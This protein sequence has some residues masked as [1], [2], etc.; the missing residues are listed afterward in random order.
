[1]EVY[2]TMR[3]FWVIFFSVFTA[4]VVALSLIFVFATRET[5]KISADVMYVNVGDTFSLTLDKKNASNSTKI[6]AESSDLSV[7]TF[8]MESSMAVAKSGGV[9]RITFT[10]TNSRYRSL[11]C[12]VMVG[13]GT[14]ENPFYIATAEDLAQIGAADSIYPA[15][16]CYRLVANIDMSQHND[17]IWAPIAEFSGV[18][19]GNGYTITN[20]VIGVNDSDNNETL[21]NAGIFGT[22]SA[23]GK[24]TNLKVENFYARGSYV[25]FGVIAGV[26]YGKIDR[27][28]IKNAFLEVDADVIGGVVG[29]NE[30]TDY[31]GDTR[32]IA[33]VSQT[34]ADVTIG[35]EQKMTDNGIVYI[36]VGANGI[37]GGIAGENIGGQIINTY[38]IG[39]VVLGE[40]GIVYGGLVGNNTYT[41]LSTVDEATSSNMAAAKIAN[42]YTAISLFSSKVGNFSNEI[43][44]GVVGRNTDIEEVVDKNGVAVTIS[45]NNITGVYYDTENL[46][47]ADNASIKDFDGIGSNNIINA[48]AGKVVEAAGYVKGYNTANMKVQANYKAN[49]KTTRIY[50]TKGTLISTKVEGTNWDF[51]KVW[52]MNSDNNGYPHLTYAKVDAEAEQEVVD[53]YIV[54]NTYQV[55]INQYNTNTDKATSVAKMIVSDAEGN[56]ISTHTSSYITMDIV[57]GFKL[58][59]TSKGV[60]IYDLDG[61]LYQ[62]ISFVLSNEDY[63]LNRIVSDEYTVS[64]AG[65]V[66]DNANVNVYFDYTN[67]VLTILDATT[68]K[69]LKL[70]STVKEG[71]VLNTYIAVIAEELSGQSNIKYNT[72]QNGTGYSY[73]AYS[74][75]P[76]NDLTLYA[77]Y[78]K[79]TT[80]S[81]PSTP[82]TPSEPTTPD[83]SE[84][85]VYEISNMTDWNKYVVAYA[86]DSDIKFVQT[87]SFSVTSSFQVCPVING[88]Y[89]GNGYTITINGTQTNYGVFDKI[90][91]NGSVY[92]LNVKYSTYNSKITSVYNDMYFGG[93]ANV[94]YGE[95]NNCKVS[96]KIYISNKIESGVAGVVGHLYSGLV[97]DCDNEAT[98]SAT[99]QAVAGIVAAMRSGEVSGCSNSGAV[100]N[101]SDTIYDYDILYNG[102]VISAGIVGY[103]Y[104]TGYSKIVESNSNTAKITSEVPGDGDG[105]NSAGIVGYTNGGTIENNRNSGAIESDYMAGGIVAFCDGATISYNTNSA[106]ILAESNVKGTNVSAGGIIAKVHNSGTV[107]YNTQSK[108]TITAKGAIPGGSEAFAGGIIGCMWYGGTAKYNKL[109]YNAYISATGVSA[110]AAGGCGRV[111]QATFSNTTYTSTWQSNCSQYLTATGTWLAFVQTNYN[112]NVY[113]V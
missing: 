76:A 75:M 45:S 87:N 50:D 34:S 16:A 98:I 21:A 17:G 72:K 100:T 24:V 84:T 38:S 103:M 89:D 107:T 44:G 94:C 33:S 108:G 85:N 23:A 97:V 68:G 49:A 79:T 80:P 96:G 73:T 7:V 19:D 28:E 29:I 6:T 32:C 112:M 67:H 35:V 77:I 83:Y 12:D 70:W 58:A 53:S 65:I 30:S 31:M 69:I 113:G 92:D 26:N 86:K 102:T 91:A 36:N 60:E 71:T 25:N 8:D 51:D 15:D 95:V 18:L 54:L 52:I 101:N 105:G 41:M 14:T 9:A 48:E 78:S 111:C 104:S 22:I 90:G 88:E 64:N 61:K 82:S 1:M 81:E 55:T 42:S 93:I 57:E 5:I 46:N 99:S 109:A 37:I 13:D 66:K 47:D 110:F 4:L 59:A 56:E 39:K 10:T 63:K 74:K 62:S 2:K 11:H 43:L 20:T 106:N 3:K 40:A 27:V